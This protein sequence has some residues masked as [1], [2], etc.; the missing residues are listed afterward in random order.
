LHELAEL[1]LLVAQPRNLSVNIAELHRAQG[2]RDA[3]R[4]RVESA[5]RIGCPRGHGHESNNYSGAAGGG[6][7]E[8]VQ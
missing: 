7:G 3:A 1:D 5:S 4:R 2:F 6:G 8:S